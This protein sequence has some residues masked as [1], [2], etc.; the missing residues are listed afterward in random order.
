MQTK[1]ALG[2]IFNFL[3]LPELKE[4]VPEV[5]EDLLRGGTPLS[6]DIPPAVALSGATFAWEEPPPDFT[7]SKKGKRGGAAAEAE[8]T[9]P[10]PAGDSRFTLHDVD[11]YVPRGKLVAVVGPVGSGKSTLL[12][13]ILGEVPRSKGDL[14]RT[15]SV[16]YVAQQA[17]IL[18]ATLRSNV[19]FGGEDDE[20][21]FRESVRV[22]A[23]Q[24]DIDVRARTNTHTHTDMYTC[25]YVTECSLHLP[26]PSTRVAHAITLCLPLGRC[27][28]EATR[29]RSG[30]AASTC[31][32]GKRPA[33]RWREP[34]IEVRVPF[35]GQLAR[36][37]QPPATRE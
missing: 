27:C 36:W 2:R 9:S 5:P 20:A 15:G 21:R 28:P 14:Y 32:A 17:W 29:P 16:A 13:S 18:N 7:A 19:T 35:W 4:E 25:V 33:C 3:D 10:A 30:S 11:L 8:A 23:L 26:P 37:P 22:S 34:C 31:R 1:I 6:P 12:S 24:Q